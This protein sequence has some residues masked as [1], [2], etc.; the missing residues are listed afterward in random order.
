MKRFLVSLLF[1]VVGLFVVD[2]LGGVILFELSQ[3][4][5]S[6]MYRKMKR[7]NDGISEDV[8][9]LGTSRAN[10]H[11][12]SS[13]LADS[14][15]KSV[16]NAGSTGSKNIYSQYLVLNQILEKHTPQL[17]VLE[18][19]TADYEVDDNAFSALS[20]FAPYFG[21]IDEVNNIY[22][23]GGS[24]YLYKFSHLY[25]YNN[26]VIA[27]L[28]GLLHSL[29]E[30]GEDNG[31]IPLSRN[32]EMNGEIEMDSI[33]AGSDSLKLKYLE[34]F[35]NKCEENNIQLIFAVSP[36]YKYSDEGLYFPLEEVAKH[37]D[38][39]Y[40]NYATKG[41]FLDSPHYF[42]DKTHLCDEGARVYTSI[43]VEDLKKI[44]N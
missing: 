39:P 1:L 17:I 27:L 21:K 33:Q 3:H 15:G 5:K 9:I 44:L 35:I 24:Y 25:R 10:H 34:K 16:Y 2:R 42:K 22:R 14:L 4:T 20:I 32:V 18:L 13:I 26:S 40:F 11:Y 41:L 43:F 19:S 6:Q 37:F 7:I 23:E 30:N 28:G 12:V 29:G 31:Y 36:K 38:I 8:V